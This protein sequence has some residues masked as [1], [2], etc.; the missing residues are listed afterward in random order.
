MKPALSAG[1]SR[2]KAMLREPLDQHIDLLLASEEHIGLV[3]PE[4]PQS[5]VRIGAELDDRRHD[6]ATALTRCKKG[7]SVAPF[8]P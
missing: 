5:G 2:Q 4:R 3:I 8:I 6:Y 1:I 7:S